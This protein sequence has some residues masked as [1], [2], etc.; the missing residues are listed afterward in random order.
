MKQ[1]DF[2]LLEF[3]N[4]S[5]KNSEKL[6]KKVIKQTYKN[7]AENALDNVV[8]LWKNA[9]L[10]GLTEFEISEDYL[11]PIRRYYRNYWLKD[12]VRILSILSAL[13]F[14]SSFYLWAGSQLIFIFAFLTMWGFSEQNFMK[15]YLKDF[16]IDKTE[17]KVITA[18]IF[19][20][21]YNLIG[22][23]TILPIVLLL[24]LF[25]ATYN[26]P[27]LLDLKASTI[28]FLSIGDLQFRTKNELFAYTNF[29]MLWVIGMTKTIKLYRR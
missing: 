2:K 18:R 27:I 10:N 25:A 1:N 4:H 13:I 29:L 20:K 11:S 16:E 12:M 5:N 6:E 28:D 8:R 24:S 19:P 17:E 15:F 14:I 7:K 22:N 26:Q 9:K 23:L 3:D 21:R